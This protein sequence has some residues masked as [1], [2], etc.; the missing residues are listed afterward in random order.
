[1]ASDEI[2]FGIV[3]LGMGYNRARIAANTPGAKL[4]C[5]CS[6]EP[7]KAEEVGK[8]LSCD[9]TMDYDE[10]L[11]RKDIDA[12]GV[13]TPSGLHCD[14]A[15]KALQAGKHA[16]TT[17]PMDISVAK[18]DAAVAAAEKAGKI[19]AVDFDSRYSPANH[20]LRMAV[21]GG[22]L[23]KVL[24]GDL[25]M[26]WYRAQSYYDGG[27]PPGWRSRKVTEG[28]SIANQGVHFVDLL[29]WFLGPVESVY[30]RSGA[31]SHQIETED[32]TMAMLTFKSGAWGLIHTTTCSVPDLGTAIE[33]NGA[34]G[35]I[36]WKDG[37]VTLY[38]SE[39]DPTTKL[40]DL[41][42]DANLPHNI[43]EDMV[44]AITKGTKVQCNG[45]EGLK[46]V[47][48]F[49]SIYESSRTGKAVKIN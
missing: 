2:R 31:F 28:G 17:K 27:S 8:E 39:V 45:Y 38:H 30:G 37:K 26:K 11:A 6:I 32:A 5:V 48:I 18:C 21:Q 40:E 1:M 20:Q 34:Q 19:L 23:G 29:Q 9:W 46:S 4:V 22:K 24:S 42:V 14:F 33:I 49:T 36:L 16:Y 44:S 15:I 41:A 13:M 35:T 3:G 47:Q 7:G 12:I 10:M 25:L 43:I